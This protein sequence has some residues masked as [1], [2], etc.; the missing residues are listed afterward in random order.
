[1]PSG[2]GDMVIIVWGILLA[3]TLLGC[4][5]GTR[6]LVRD[7]GAGAF[8]SAASESPSL[9]LGSFLISLAVLVVPAFVLAHMEGLM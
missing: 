3:P 4:V 1:M 9:V 6:L 5:L 7:L 2:P 8:E